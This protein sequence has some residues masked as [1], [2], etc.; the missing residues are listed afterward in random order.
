M[1]TA[2]NMRKRFKNNF[3]F[4]IGLHIN[5]KSIREKNKTI[6]IFFKIK[7]IIKHDI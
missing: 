7:N 5:C 3:N 1:A 2:K 4:V 6:H